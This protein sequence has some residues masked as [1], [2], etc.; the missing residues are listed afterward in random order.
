MLGK[1][2]S[3]SLGKISD[4][5]EMTGV[6]RIEQL[7]KLNNGRK[8]NLNAYVHDVLFSHVKFLSDESF[9][10][11]PKI[12]EEAMETM[13]IKEEWDKL[14]HSEDTKKEIRIALTHRR[15]Y[16]KGQVFKKYKGM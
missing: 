13:G 11:S 1:D 2:I 6:V 4:V 5:T 12:L 15:S 10:A 7:L 16:I 9:A 3:P 14:Q 8:A